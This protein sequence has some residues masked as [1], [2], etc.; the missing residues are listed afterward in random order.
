M[1]ESVTYQAIVEEGRVQGRDL[2]KIEEAQQAILLVGETLL[3]APAADAKEQILALND[4]QE[5]HQIL[6]RVSKA[7]DWS[8]LLDGIA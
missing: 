1:K 2:G 6:R 8:T 4:L 5:L 3:G 7:K